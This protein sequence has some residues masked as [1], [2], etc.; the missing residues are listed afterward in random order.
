MKAI[1]CTRYPAL[2]DGLRRV[3]ILWTLYRG[4]QRKARE[5]GI[6]MRHVRIQSVRTEIRRQLFI[7]R[8][9]REALS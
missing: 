4:I 9:I 3:E 7:T 8:Q 1:P 2:Q 5:Q 6:D